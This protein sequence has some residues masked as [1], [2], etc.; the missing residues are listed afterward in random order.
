MKGLMIAVTILLG[1]YYFLGME[2]QSV[3]KQSVSITAKQIEQAGG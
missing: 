2:L 3:V 1:A